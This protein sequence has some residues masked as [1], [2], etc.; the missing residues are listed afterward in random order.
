MNKGTVII[1]FNIQTKA[2]DIY[3]NLATKTGNNR[4][5][6]DDFE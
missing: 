6:E 2:Y 1:R 4:F 3:D 5:L